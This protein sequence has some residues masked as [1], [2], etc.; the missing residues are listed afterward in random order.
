VGALGDD[1]KL[2]LHERADVPA[3]SHRGFEPEPGDPDV[4]RTI[5]AGRAAE[6]QRGATSPEP[7]LYVDLAGVAAFLEL[8]RDP[9]IGAI[10]ERL[11]AELAGA[12]RARRSPEH[13][14][15]RHAAVRAVVEPVRPAVQ[16]P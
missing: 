2:V 5:R 4:M 8:Q 14:P 10:V 1:W 3:I 7:L 13:V 12:L 16:I 6:D 9:A 11:H 15:T